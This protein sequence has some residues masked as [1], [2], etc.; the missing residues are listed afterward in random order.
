MDLPETIDLSEPMELA[1]VDRPEGPVEDWAQAFEAWL[2][3]MAVNTQTAYKA[4][5]RA[6]LA[7][8]RLKP[9]QIGRGD[10]ARWV[11]SLRQKGLAEK[12]I[13]MRV[14]GIS[15]FFRYAGNDFT[16]TRNGREEPL[17]AGL[18]PAGARTLRNKAAAYKRSGFLSP[19]ESRLLLTVVSMRTGI[20]AKRDY[21]LFLTYLMTGR[22]NSEVRQLKWGDLETAMDGKA[23]YTWSGKGQTDVKHEL[24]APCLEAIRAWL[25]A[26]GR[27]RSI[28][29]GDTIFTATND[30]ASRLPG[31]K[32]W[33][34]GAP[35]SSKQVGKLLRY[36][37]AL[38]GI[39]GHIHVHM[40][41]HS[42]AMLRKA[43][44]DD[45]EAISSQLVHS[46]LAVTQIYLHSLEGR[47]DESWE[48]VAALLGVPIKNNK[49]RKKSKE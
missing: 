7:Q 34:P 35:L 20:Q 26:D 21:A 6:L 9:W 48:K 39:E 3:G 38:G 30:H 36:Y 11:E 10:V 19:E 16:V 33:A 40:L 17:F 27:L 25:V 12:T 49:I 13:N 42:A 4:A 23:Y 28:Q 32:T 29:P 8:C 1:T 37:A 18:N 24:P 46:S 14:A 44:G 45:V 15:S 5:W 2:G 43:V 41:R 31:G 47:G 22:R